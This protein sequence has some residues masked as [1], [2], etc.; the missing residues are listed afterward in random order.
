M[1]GTRNRRRRY[2]TERRESGSNNKTNTTGKH[3]RTEVISRCNTTHG[4]TLTKIIET[5]TPVEK[6]LNKTDPWKW[7]SEKEADLNRIKQ[8]LTE[9]PCLAHYAKDKDNMV[10]TDASKTGLRITL[11]Q[12]QHDGKIQPKA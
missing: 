9:C 8:M 3:E 4:K 2:K 1:A 10:T 12:K 5:N 11:W 6:K 7:G